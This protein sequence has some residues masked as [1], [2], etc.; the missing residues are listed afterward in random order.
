MPNLTAFN[1]TID[2]F[3][4]GPN[5]ELDWPIIGGESKVL[6]YRPGPHPG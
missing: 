1:F 2:G 5:D 3:H 6:S 4:E